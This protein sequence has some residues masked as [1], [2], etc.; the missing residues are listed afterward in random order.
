M[1]KLAL[2]LTCF[3]MST[4]VYSYS[5]GPPAD[6]CTNAAMTP[7]FGHGTSA[8]SGQSPYEVTISANEYQPGGSLTGKG[9]RSTIYVYQ[10]R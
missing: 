1:F 4:R 9:T 6:T 7:R 10:T 5:N 2:V 3:L 8:Q